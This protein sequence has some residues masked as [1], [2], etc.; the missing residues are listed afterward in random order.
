MC[1]GMDLRTRTKRIFAIE[2]YTQNMLTILDLI[3]NIFGRPP[4]WPLNEHKNLHFD[5]EYDSQQ[6]K[7]MIQMTTG[8]IWIL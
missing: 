7:I 8:T 5:N 1:L 6:K 4:T 2:L 3:V